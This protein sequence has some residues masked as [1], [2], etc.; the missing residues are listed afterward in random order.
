M[1]VG[2]LKLDDLLRVESCFER[3]RVEKDGTWIADSSRAIILHEA[4]LP[5]VYYLPLEDV[6]PEYLE[7][8]ATQTH[9]PF[10]GNATYWSVKVGGMTTPDAV[11]AYEDPYVEGEALRGY[12]AFDAAKVSAIYRGTEPVVPE[13]IK[14]V[15]YANPLVGWVVGAATNAYSEEDLFKSFC[16]ALQ[17]AGIAATRLRLVIP[18]LHPQ[19]FAT[20]YAWSKDEDKV[21]AFT[22][23]HD[24]L[25]RP[26]FA[27][28]PFATILNG[29]G[30]VRRRLEGADI[31]LDYPIVK[32]LMEE[33]ATDY[34]AMPFKFTDGQ[35]CIIT[36]TSFEPGGFH[37]T[38]LNNIYEVLPSL[39]RH[40]EVHAQRRTSVGLLEAFLGA[41]TGRRVLQGQVKLGD[42]EHIHAVIWFSD[43]RNS[44]ALSESMAQDAY[45]AHLNSY[46]ECVAGAVLDAGGEVLRYI[47]DA[48]LAI[49]P[50]SDAPDR[51]RVDATGTAE[52]CR[53]AIKA[54]Q[55]VA[56]RVA[57]V[58]EE[59]A[60]DC[61]PIKYGIG[62]H[63]GD[64]TYGNIGIA[65]R[66]EFTVI[67][68][69]ANQAARVE[70]MTK[71]LGHVVLTSAAFAAQYAGALDSVG[72]HKLKGV[73]G[74]HELF[75]PI[76]DID[77]SDAD[78]QKA[79]EEEEMLVAAKAV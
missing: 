73:S 63:L 9:C 36:L 37:A 7:R 26:I 20:L 8:S 25:T 21:E 22:A 45:L 23:P 18:N 61:P 38:D 58:N 6:R 55:D 59:H 19:V 40:F 72:S 1:T 41:H 54:T 30:G 49:F 12:V 69:A 32:E 10:K 53:R 15:T 78:K 34:C 35:I 5:S 77:L 57:K 60:E 50:I 64:V 75:T 2:N 27:D 33:G 39:S 52:A 11:W 71:E 70:S 79:A 68:K 17:D 16:N 74:E 76:G 4:N 14:P 24:I 3:I 31:R 46:F 48:V 42:G 56:T 65:Q 28:S 66:L 62:L 13:E 44:T 43:F 29:A 47:G 51:V 67:G